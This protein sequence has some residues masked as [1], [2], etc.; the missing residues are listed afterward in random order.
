[1]D[2]VIFD[3]RYADARACADA[4]CEQGAATWST[5]RNI[6]ALWHGPDSYRSL[7]LARRIAGFTPHS[8]SSSF[9]RSLRAAV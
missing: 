8:D 4:M 9:A 7:L 6:A 1:V 2:V 5:G 3:E